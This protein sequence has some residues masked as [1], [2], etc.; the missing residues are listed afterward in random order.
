MT[1]V[2]IVGGGYGGIVLAKALDDVAEVVLVEQKDTFVNHA[3]A[4]RAVVDRRWAE[5]IFMPYDRLLARGRVV[6]GTALAV[7]GTTVSVT[8]AGDI[9]ADHLVLA[10]G[11]AYPFPAKHLESSAAL[12]RARIERAHANLERCERVL[13][14]GAGDVGVELV[15]EITSA[16]PGIGVVL[17][18]ACAQILPNRGYLP[19]LRQSIARQLERRG[20]EVITG[21]TLAWLPPVDPGVLSPFRLATTGGRR[22]EADTWFRAYGASAA[23]GFLGE[24]Y[25][26]IRHYDGTIRVDEHLRVVDHPGVWAIGDITDV[27]ETKRADAA[28][29]HAEVVAANIRSLIEGG[30]AEAVYA[31]K[32][33]HVVLPLGPDGGASQ[34]LRDGVRVV[35]GPEETARMKGE[36]LFLGYVA[37]ALGAE[38]RAVRVRSASR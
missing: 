13:V 20:V 27:R 31:P 30:T 32:P 34:V 11:T 2:T 26:E 28:R 15:G 24:D 7:R 37:K 12:A 25:D 14:V 35:V 23:T 33:E 8:G 36:D 22:L 9:G 3:A 38:T 19:E 29:A 6:H 10:T 4:L 1:R 21:D 5:R 16:F 17:L 18:E